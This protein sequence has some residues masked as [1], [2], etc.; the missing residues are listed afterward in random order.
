MKFNNLTLE[1]RKIHVAVEAEG[2]ELA[3]RFNDIVLKPGQRVA[4]NGAVR[5]DKN[6]AFIP[7]VTFNV[8]VSDPETGDI[9]DK[10]QMKAIFLER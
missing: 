9:I 1:P 4:L 6:V 5:K 8:T 3:M 2:Y 10:Q 7:K